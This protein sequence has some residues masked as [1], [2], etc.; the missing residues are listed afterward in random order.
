VLILA[1]DPGYAHLGWA[2]LDVT[3]SARRRRIVES[4]SYTGPSDVPDDVRMNAAMDVVVNE[5][6]MS[7]ASAVAV[8]DYIW[9]GPRSATRNGFAVARMVGRIEGLARHA[10]CRLVTLSRPEVLRHY[11][12]TGKAPKR[13]VRAFIETM[14]G[15]RPANEHEVDAV[16]LGWVAAARLEVTWAG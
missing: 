8:E 6:A 16:A 4:G 2:L 11:G 13:R 12:L 5:L 15:Y 9:I 1:V 14:T 7:N 10:G 3:G